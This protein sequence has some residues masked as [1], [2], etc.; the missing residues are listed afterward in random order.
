M[1]AFLPVGLLLIAAVLLSA[2]ILVISTLLGPRIKAKNKL[3]P[4]EC[5]VEPIGEAQRPFQSR[6]YLVAVLFLLIYVEAAFFLPWALV[7]RESLADGG[8]LLAAMGAF[9]IFMVLGLF[10]IY[11]KNYLKLN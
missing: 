3:T 7:Y 9:L 2:A 6:Y 10:Y 4:Y 8:M 11:R 5:G 1:E